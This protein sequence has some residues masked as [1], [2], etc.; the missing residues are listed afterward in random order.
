MGFTVRIDQQFKGDLS[1]SIWFLVFGMESVR[2]VSITNTV[3]T[4]RGLTPV[5]VLMFVVP[6][7]WG[8]MG[9]G[10]GRTGDVTDLPTQMVYGCIHGGSRTPKYSTDC[11]PRPNITIRP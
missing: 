9:V 6:V 11:S 5:F 1:L 4:V 2:I 7:G 10:W 3:R 8:R